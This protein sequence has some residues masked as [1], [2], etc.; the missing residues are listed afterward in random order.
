M[1]VFMNSKFLAASVLHLWLEVS[2]IALDKNQKV[3]F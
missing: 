3:S 2:I 1:A